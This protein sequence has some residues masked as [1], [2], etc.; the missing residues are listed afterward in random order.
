MY[1]QGLASTQAICLQGLYTHLPGA[2]LSTDNK[3]KVCKVSA[4]TLG[5]YKGILWDKRGKHDLSISDYLILKKTHFSNMHYT[6]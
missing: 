4:T 3:R 1:V 2:C 5:R 6:D